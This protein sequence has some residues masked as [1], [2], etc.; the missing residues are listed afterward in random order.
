MKPDI[1]AVIMAFNEKDTLKSV[2]TEIDSVLKAIG[3]SYEVLIIDDGSS[4][5]TAAIADKLTQEF[6]HVR[7]IH[8]DANKG[9]GGVYRTGFAQARGDLVT[10][11]PADGQFPAS[12]IKEFVKLLN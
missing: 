9:L 1:S 6:I 10:F 8:H 11:F 7:P 5:G 4:D 2:V 3:Q 12:I